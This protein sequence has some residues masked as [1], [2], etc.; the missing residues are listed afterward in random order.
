MNDRNEQLSSAGWRQPRLSHMEISLYVVPMYSLFHEFAATTSGRTRFKISGWRSRFPPKK[1][2]CETG[3]ATRAF[4]C[5]RNMHH[6]CIIYARHML[7]TRYQ[8]TSF[9]ANTT[10][11]ERNWCYRPPIINIK[12]RACSSKSM[13]MLPARAR[14]LRHCNS[15]TSHIPCPSSKQPGPLA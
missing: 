12:R 15:Y 8:G 13:T 9:A 2:S 5:S 10:N 6:P 1:I 3:A 7:G 4:C 14:D 11:D